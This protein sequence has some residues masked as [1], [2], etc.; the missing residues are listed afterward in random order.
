VQREREADAL[1]LGR[2]DVRSF[3]KEDEILANQLYEPWEVALSDL[4]LHM[5]LEGDCVG[6]AF[7]RIEAIGVLLVLNDIEGER[8]GLRLETLTGKRA[9]GGDVVVSVRCW[10]IGLRQDMV[11]GD[12]LGRPEFFDYPMVN[13]FVRIHYT[14]STIIQV[15]S[16]G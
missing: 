5:C 1:A 9:H 15:E 10:D 8:A 13:P 2:A 6:V 14:Y 11:H 4:P 12:L 16:S 3:P 7:I